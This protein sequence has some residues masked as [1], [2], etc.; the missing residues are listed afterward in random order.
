M[1]FL[2][3]K[4]AKVF[5]NEVQ[6]SS[7]I[8]SWNATHSRGMGEVTTI[9]QD[10][11]KWV[12]GLK[13]GSISLAGPQDTTGQSLHAE[14]LSSVGVD[15][16]LQVTLLPDGDAVGKPAL[17]AVTDP[18]EWAIDASVS[19]AVGFTFNAAA[20]ESVEM[21]YV[22]HALGAETA[23]VNS[24][25]VDRVVSSSL[26]A[27]AVLHVTA[28]SGLTNAI[29]K[30]QHS[31]DNS[32][33]SDLVTFSTVTAIGQQRATVA[34]GTTINRYLRVNTDVTGTGSVTFLVAAAPR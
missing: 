11:A 34:A 5:V 13:T 2:H 16:G 19:E 29:I 21:G 27:A 1:A 33:W 12:P 8:R 22:L 15:N 10:G 25:A 18:T 17:F 26:G 3:G 9:Q 28:Y 31:P 6:V 32:V 23:D 20:D 24:T 14:I 7:T 30:V 4:G